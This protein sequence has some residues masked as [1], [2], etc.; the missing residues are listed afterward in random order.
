M[1]DLGPPPLILPAAPAIIRPA[2]D[3]LLRPP[4]WPSTLAE[5]LDAIAR[6]GVTD[7]QVEQSITWFSPAFSGRRKLKLKSASVNNGTSATPGVV[8]PAGVSSKDML[9]LFLGGNADRTITTPS[10]W[11]LLYFSNDNNAGTIACYYKV[12]TGSETNFNLAL[13]SS[14]QWATAVYCLVGYKGVPEAAAN[15]VLTSSGT[16][17]AAPTLTPSWGN[18]KAIWIVF[19]STQITT[20]PTSVSISSGYSGVQPATFYLLT[21]WKIAKL[22]SDTPGPF[23]YTG[24]AGRSGLIQTVALQAAA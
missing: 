6:A 13:N 7:D 14:T 12:A 9:I 5:R 20:A 8:I 23:A 15:R 18:K 4:G 17:L 11:T 3:L 21:G 19:R 24:G 16:Q 22:A 1:I 10:G 2:D